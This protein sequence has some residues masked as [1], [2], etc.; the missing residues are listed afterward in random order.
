[1]TRKRRQRRRLRMQ[2]ERK[3]LV[4]WCGLADPLARWEVLRWLIA[5]D[6]LEQEAKLYGFR[7]P[8]SMRK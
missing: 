1:M 2:S 6:R 7:I 4:Y 5:G 3:T 8:R